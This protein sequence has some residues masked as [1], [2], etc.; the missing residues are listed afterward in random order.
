MCDKTGETVTVTMATGWNMQCLTAIN[1]SFPIGLRL[2]QGTLFPMFSSGVGITYLSSLDE[3][4]LVSLRRKRG[5]ASIAHAG[6]YR[7]AG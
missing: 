2:D 5:T 4:A 3:A 1:G 7:Q 6:S